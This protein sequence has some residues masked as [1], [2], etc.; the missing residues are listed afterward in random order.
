MRFSGHLRRGGVAAQSLGDLR[1]QQG[2]AGSADAAEQRDGRIKA[3][4]VDSREVGTGMR[5]QSFR[6]RV[7]NGG[8]FSMR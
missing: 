2:R 6:M 1:R 7:A 4:A 8:R 3:N 5:L